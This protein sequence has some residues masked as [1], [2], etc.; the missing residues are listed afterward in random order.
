M[1]YTHIGL[2]DQAKGI[3]NLPTDSNWLGS[4]D[5]SGEESQHICSI[6]QH[7][8]S[9]SGV[10]EG[11]FQSPEG[12]ECHFSD[13]IGSDASDDEESP[14]GMPGQKKTPP[15]TDGVLVEDRGL[16]PLTFWLPAKRSPS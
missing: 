10:R 6:S 2:E 5:L 15:V 8:C 9:K 1:G 13:Q 14:Y 3:Q 7:I 4:P 16:E 11:H 12:S